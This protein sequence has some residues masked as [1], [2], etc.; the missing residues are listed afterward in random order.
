MDIVEMAIHP[1]EFDLETQPVSDMATV[2]TLLH[3]GISCEEMLT[4][5]KAGELPALNLPETQWP[6]V[7]IMDKLG[8]MAIVSQVIVEEPTLKDLFAE[9]DEIPLSIDERIEKFIVSQAIGL[10]AL[11]QLAVQESVDVSQVAA[12]DRTHEFSPGQHSFQEFLKVDTMLRSGVTTNQIVTLGSTGNL[13]ILTAPETQTALMRIVEERGFR[14]I[15]RE[16][17][18]R[19]I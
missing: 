19:L 4:I 15:A 1:D 5:V 11:C 2:S 14:A 13:P 10:R 9:I 12:L 7:Q 8:Q 17:I 18:R 3:E 16:V 6:L